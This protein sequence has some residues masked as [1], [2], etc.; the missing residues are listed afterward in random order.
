[1]LA[2]AH[3]LIDAAARSRVEVAAHKECDPLLVVG[4]IKRFDVGKRVSDYLDLRQLDVT[5]A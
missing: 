2:A 4:L 1:M 3:E 5:S